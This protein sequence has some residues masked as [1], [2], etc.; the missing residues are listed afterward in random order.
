MNKT[1]SDCFTEKPIEEFFKD[2]RRLTGRGHLCNTC[3]NKR[4]RAWVEKNLEKHKEIQKASRIKNYTT[5]KRRKSYSDKARETGKK[6]KQKWYT[7]NQ[8]L[9]VAQATMRKKRVRIRTPKWLTKEDKA[10]IANF[11]AWA[12][13]ISDLTGEKQ[14]VDHIV[15]LQGKTVSGL[16]VPWNLQILSQKENLHKL[17]KFA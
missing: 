12:K 7:E 6:W 4:N 9:C 16:H 2:K 10:K 1:C 11:Y 17:N 3:K 5:E 14:H 13:I 8:S 15:P